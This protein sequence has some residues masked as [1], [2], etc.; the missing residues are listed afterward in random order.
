MS[1]S[2][3]VPALDGLRGCA[4]IAVLCFHSVL[5]CDFSRVPWAIAV[6]WGSAGVDLFF[7]LSGFLI[8]RILLAAGDRVNFGSFFARRALRILPAYYFVLLGMYLLLPTLSDAFRESEARQQFWLYALFLQNW[9]YAFNDWA[10]W[11]YISHFWSLAVEEQFY[12]L[13]PFVVAAAGRHRLPYVC[14]GIFFASFAIIVGVSLIGDPGRFIYS[15]TVTRMGVIAAG[16]WV[17]CADFQRLQHLARA[18]W[19]LLACSGFA[20]LL[21]VVWAP[22]T[23]P[24]IGYMKLLCAALAPAVLIAL[25]HTQRLPLLPR[26]FLELPPLRWFGKYSYGLYLLHYPVIGVLVERVG[27]SLEQAMIWSPTLAPLFFLGIVLAVTIPIAVAMFHTIELTALRIRPKSA[28]TAKQ[29]A[30]FQ[31]PADQTVVR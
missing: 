29:L 19:I 23:L 26:T 10:D 13:W 30:A 14:A 21:F 9:D 31:P 18:P 15:S 6:R 25:I 4:I 5:V 12:L 20:Y 3:R 27:E 2:G 28:A 8:T 1:N 7:V 17:A 11:R 22:R 16:A 24:G